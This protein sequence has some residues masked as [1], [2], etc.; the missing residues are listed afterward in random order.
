MNNYPDYREKLTYSQQLALE[1]EIAQV[2]ATSNH[3]EDLVYRLYSILS[4]VPKKYYS[5]I[6]SCFR[7]LCDLPEST[8]FKVRNEVVFG[9][10]PMW[11]WQDKCLSDL[12]ENLR[13]ATRGGV[14]VDANI[15]EAKRK[16]IESA[17]MLFCRK[18]AM[19]LPE[20]ATNL[21]NLVLEEST[22]SPLH[23]ACTLIIPEIQNF[24]KN[25]TTK[26]AQLAVFDTLFDVRD[27]LCFKLEYDDENEPKKKS[28]KETTRVKHQVNKEVVVRKEISEELPEDLPTLEDIMQGINDITQ[29]FFDAVPQSYAE[30][31][32]PQQNKLYI[33]KKYFKGSGCSTVLKTFTTKAEAE[34]YIKEI[35]QGYPELKKTCTFV[36]EHQI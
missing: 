28:Q 30:K 33:V 29:T 7:N 18:I 19:A 11:I 31:A 15:P 36:I 23:K 21:C 22:L 17:F 10:I 20:E 12:K 4:T 26:K 32:M 27:T 6:L 13:S 3:N 25:K 14:N 1:G 2:V 8:F 5:F 24:P 16:I 9:K 35:L 34:N